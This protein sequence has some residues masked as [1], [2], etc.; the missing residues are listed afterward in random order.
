MNTLCIIPCGVKKI[1]NRNPGAG[2]TKARHVYI[3]PFSKKCREYADKFY[4]SSYCILSAKHGF[5]F[6]DDIVLGPYNV[7]FKKKG[8]NPITIGELL[9][10][11]KEKGLG[12]Y[13]NIVALGGKDYTCIVRAVFPDKEIYAPLDNCGRIG[14][15]M[16]KLKKAIERGT[17]L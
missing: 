12:E 9:T 6:P 4:P 3:G 11:S 17:P 10:E 15:M 5:L 2:P 1:W 14:N 13:E 7:S 8:T 16:G